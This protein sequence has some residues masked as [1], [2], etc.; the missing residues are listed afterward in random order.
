MLRNFLVVNSVFW[1]DSSIG[2]SGQEIYILSLNDTIEMANSNI[3]T[4]LVRGTIVD[5]GGNINEDPLFD[6]LTLLS[7]SGSSP[8]FN[9]G[10]EEYA[11]QYG[12]TPSPAYDITGMPRP[13]YGFYDIGAYEGL[14]DGIRDPFTQGSTLAVQ[15]YPNPFI[16]SIS[17]EYVLSGSSRVKIG[18]FNTFGQLV[19]EPVNTSQPKGEHI[20]NWNAGNLPAGMYFYRIEAGGMVGTGKVVKL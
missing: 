16:T 1:K 3:D 10:I 18:I 20:L 12:V 9:T 5:G 17:F 13:Q 8:C 19:A 7:I 2:V 4:A 11:G 14:I 6:D 15:S